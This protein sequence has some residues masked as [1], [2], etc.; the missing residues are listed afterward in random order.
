[1]GRQAATATALASGATAAGPSAPVPSPM[2]PAP[3]TFQPVAAE[4][5]TLPRRAVPEYDPT[6]PPP[7]EP[8]PAPA[9]ASESLT[10][11]AP[12]TRRSWGQE[13]ILGAPD[14]EHAGDVPT[15]WASREPDGG[16]E[17][18]QAGFDREVGIAEVRIRETYNPGAIS[19][20][21]ALV[22]G[23]ETVL[24]EGTAAGGTVP[25]DFVVRPPFDVRAQSVT[26]HLDTTRI[27]GWNELDAVELVG[28][29]GS[30]QWAT[31]AH[32]SSTFAER[33][34]VRRDFAN[35]EAD[36]PLR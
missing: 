36:R 10:A 25:R 9:P 33:M 35:P 4:A 12:P 3:A 29:D 32:A 31:S 1:M 14:T 21:T 22:G 5:P 19:K 24:W 6:R 20:V 15:A 18:L 28:R 27:P 2:T 30:R 11:F 23:Q 16:P 34:S 8:A 17:W 7:P 26:V 13:Q